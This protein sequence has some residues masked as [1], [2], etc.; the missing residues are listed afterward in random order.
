MNKILL[1]PFI[2]FSYSIISGAND[3]LDKSQDNP[4]NLLT[5]VNAWSEGNYVLAHNLL[6]PLS[7]EGNA[8]AQYIIGLMYFR[9]KVV[10]KDHKKS[11]E[12][13]YLSAEQ[14]YFRAEHKLGSIYFSSLLGKPDYKKAIKW[15][16]RASR[17][18]YAP[19]Q[20]F[21]AMMYENGYGIKQDYMLAHMWFNLASK[22]NIIAKDERDRIARKL[23]PSQ[24]IDS[25]KM[26]E[27]CKNKKYKNCY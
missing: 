19:S 16:R 18:G 8:I 5:G 12:Y 9:G 17:H 7:V 21:L 6:K 4:A 14:G 13:M 15:F 25:Q 1:I 22:K 2:L 20:Y 11:I 24:V 27:E 26:A 10:K 23:S 3:L